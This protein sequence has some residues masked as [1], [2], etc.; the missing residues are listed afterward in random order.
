MVFKKAPNAK[1]GQLEFDLER[2]VEPDR[3]FKKGGR[4]FYFFDFDDN[5]A[6]LDTAI[7]LFE[8]KSGRAIEISSGELA[9]NSSIIG[10]SGRYKNFEM[11]FDDS[12]GSFRLFTDEKIGIFK[13]LFGKR[14]RFVVD[15][16]RALQQ[17]DS[18]WK[19]PSWNCFY[20][21]TFNN[22][23][24]TIITA[25]GHQPETIKDAIRLF[26][27]YG[28]IPHEPNYLDLYPV[29]LPLLKQMWCEQE[30]KQLNV[31]ELKRKAISA[32]VEKAIEVYGYSPFHRFGMSDD[33][34]RNIELVTEEMRL[35]KRKY[36][37][38]S[39]FVIYTGEKGDVKREVF[40]HETREEQVDIE[41]MMARQLS[42]FDSEEGM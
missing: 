28:H 4:S 3:N 2:P 34:P 18:F 41:Q 24:M 42:L 19:G 16:D 40:E 11:D 37:E 20:H 35:I 17:V 25:R 36:H 5:V 38:M 22:R 31:A 9:Q 10:K 14:Q 29:S 7:I 39:F 12:V 26:V 33:D 6:Y 32:A 1:A 27:K 13:K 23:P 21:A 30:K 8:K 15:L